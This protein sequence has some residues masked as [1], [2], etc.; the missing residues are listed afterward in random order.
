MELPTVITENDS[1]EFSVYGHMCKLHLKRQ[2]LQKWKELSEEDMIEILV[3][4]SH[5]Q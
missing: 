3:R 4:Q 2:K 5:I 1:Q